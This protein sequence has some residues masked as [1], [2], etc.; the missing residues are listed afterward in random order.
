VTIVFCAPH[1]HLVKVGVTATAL[2]LALASPLRAQSELSSKVGSDRVS[3][4]HVVQDSIRLLAIQHA[5]RIGFQEKTRRELGGHFFGDYRRSVHVPRQWGDA[6]SVVTDYIGHPGQGAASGFIWLQRDPR[7]PNAFVAN[8][9]Y[10]HSRLRGM[11]FAAVYSLQFELGPLSEASI[12]NV[13]MNPATAGWV[14]HVMTPVG[15]LAIMVAEDVLDR[16]VI[17]NIERHTGSAVLRAVARMLLNPAR[18]TANVA[19]V[20][21]PW[22]RADRPL[23]GS[24]YSPHP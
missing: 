4:T 17:S 2:L 12:G 18:A 21:A 14:D 13:G 6:D 3:I 9:S 7:A 20:Q 5:A 23:E 10:V 19:A 16:F 22:Y 24:G 11:A 8:R 1:V 15:G